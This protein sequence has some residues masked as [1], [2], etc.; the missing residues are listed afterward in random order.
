MMFND[1]VTV[2]NKYKG[3]DGTEKWQR[4]VLYG[5]FWNSIKGAVTRRTGVASADSL[6][7]IIPRSVTALFGRQYAPPKKWAEMED[8]SGCWTL[9]SGDIV[10]KGCVEYEIT[11]STKELAGYDDVL[12]ITSVD[13]K[14]FG[15]NM[16]HWEV[17][18]K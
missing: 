16:A 18:G 2:Y 6:Q 9:Q 4:T 15:G 12:S 3:Q 8:K 5:V 1:T 17:S 10:V 14:G 13:Y 11:R 7:L